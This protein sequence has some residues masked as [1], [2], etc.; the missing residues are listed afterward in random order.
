MISEEIRRE[1]F[2]SQSQ[3]YLPEVVSR[4]VSQKIEHQKKNKKRSRMRR[5]YDNDK[6]LE[7][8]RSSI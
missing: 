5:Y 8:T 6:F 4:E 1:E 7:P 2:Y 3:Q